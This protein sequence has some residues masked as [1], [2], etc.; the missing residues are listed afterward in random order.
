[1][2]Q[3]V[4]PVTHVSCGRAWPLLQVFVPGEALSAEVSAAAGMVLASAD[5]LFTERTL[6]QACA[7]ALPKPAAVYLGSLA[8][9]HA[10]P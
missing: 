10:H 2:L 9:M 5:L 4:M 6:E 1:M 3:T 8:L 7:Q